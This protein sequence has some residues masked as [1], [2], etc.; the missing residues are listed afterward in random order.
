MPK[1][2]VWQI[3]KGLIETKLSPLVPPTR[4]IDRERLIE[5]VFAKTDPAQVIEIVGAAGSGKSL[6]MGQL[7]L[8]AV[9]KGSK[10]CWL[11]I[12]TE[13]DDPA[14]FLTY[15]AAALEVIEPALTMKM[16]GSLSGPQS[17]RPDAMFQILCEG[18][19]TIAHDALIFLDDFQ[20]ISDPAILGGM[21][22][23][24]AA[25][26]SNVRLVIASR[27]HPDLH[28][29]R[30][31]LEGRLLRLDQQALNF[32]HDE[33]ATMLAKSFELTLR[34]ETNRKLLDTTEG[35]VA[36]LQLAA[37]AI[38]KQPDHAAN[39]VDRFSGANAELAT[40]L[41][42]G[43]F[44]S[45]DPELQKFLISTGPLKRMNADLCAHVSGLSDVDALINRI[46]R[47][48][49]FFVTLDENGHWFRFH[50]L[51][52]DFL[53]AQL[54]K[55]GADAFGHVCTR[56]SEWFQREG[57]LT[58]AIQ[59][60]LMAKRYED[61]AGL[62]A[63]YSTH[64]AQRLGDHRTVLDWMRRLPERYH[65]HHPLIMLNHAWSLT[66]ARSSDAGMAI[67]EQVKARLA[68]D[69]M[70]GWHLSEGEK[71]EALCLADVIIAISLASGDRTEEARDYAM[72]ALDRWPDATDIHLGA[73][74]NVIAYSC[75]PGRDPESGL[76]AAAKASIHGVRASSRYIKV[77]A[78][79]ISAMLCVEQGRLEEAEGHRDRAQ[80]DIASDIGEESFSGS[81]IAVLDA[82]IAYER[83]EFGQ[84]MDFLN[85]SSEQLP[86]IATMEPVRVLHT[87]E[88][89]ALAALGKVRDAIVC[90]RNGQEEALARTVPRV[91]VALAVEELRL[92]ITE[93]R[94]EEYEA[95]ARRWGFSE[96]ENLF[97]I[98]LTDPI[99]ARHR[100][101][102]G[103]RLAIARGE[104]SNALGML[105]ELTAGSRQPNSGRAAIEPGLLRAIAM[106]HAGRQT[107]AMRTFS[108]ATA[109]AAPSGMAAPFFEMS[110]QIDEL[111]K[112]VTDRRGESDSQFLSQQ[113][114]FERH[115][116]AMLRGE[117][118][119][120]ITSSSTGTDPTAIQELTPRELELVNLL[121]EGKSNSELA[122]ML[123]LSL[124]TVKW[125][126]SNIYG[127]LGVKNRSAAIARA[128]QNK[129]IH[130]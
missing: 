94:D 99:L 88:A 37:L 85:R 119:I 76:E 62:I 14:A 93:G 10:C 33:T 84:A 114:G 108:D 70:A 41:M 74:Y 47:E 129:I 2:R 3:M 109:M 48:N 42:E 116:L 49:L 86:G 73:L 61:A 11:T 29:S 28:L 12:E 123:L 44:H 1:E 83:C 117:T 39:L 124:P 66:F 5:R 18:V 68:S 96:P 82:V 95:L 56:A 75:I 98:D 59:Y 102:A 125:H 79:W 38:A 69:D 110:P 51:F 64:V 120:E 111:I 105:M 112:A 31:A 113:I 16:Q 118:A 71:D 26:P 52:S 8:R 22:R 127:K 45:L 43:V 32:D 35:W 100:Q 121:A 17:A 53:T 101:M 77:W 40:Y 126:L 34:P 36:G 50:H 65:S 107:E 23:L 6:L 19:S 4:S 24:M 20:H 128:R 60:Q 78:C 27:T 122:D 46:E 97:G 25:L 54:H 87:T 13:D 91:A 104:W 55:R 30:L 58:E 130:L 15:L 63:Q 21:Q 103:C 80:D 81:L 89:R 92:L 9:E 115:V 90:L 106:W 7:F 72:V 67:A 57:L